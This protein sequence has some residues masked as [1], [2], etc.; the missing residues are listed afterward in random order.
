M[1]LIPGNYSPSDWGFLSDDDPH[2]YEEPRCQFRKHF[3]F[4]TYS[5]SKL[6]ECILKTASVQWTG[7]LIIILRQ[8]KKM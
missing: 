6:S 3:T 5:S 8:S 4:V 2:M 7:Q 1:T